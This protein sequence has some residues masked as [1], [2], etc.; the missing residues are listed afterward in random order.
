VHSKALLLAALAAVLTAAAPTVSQSRPVGSPGDRNANKI[1]DSLD[2]RL[3]RMRSDQ[4]LRV[5]VS[6]RH[7]ATPAAVG[8]LQQAVGRLKVRARFSII[9]A[10]AATL[11]KRQV[12]QVAARPGVAR[13]GLDRVVH[14]LNDTSEESFGVTKARL[15]AP[16]LDG[17]C[18]VASD[19]QCAPGV[20]GPDDLVA[21][22]LDTGIN[23][24][25][26]DLDGGKVTKFVD[27]TSGV[28]AET[29]PFDDFGHGTHVAATIAGDGDGTSDHRYQGVAPRAALVGVKVLDGSG[30]GLESWILAGIDWVIANRV[31]EGIEAMSLSLGGG[32]ACSDGLDDSDSLAQAVNHAVDQGLVV[33]VAAGNDG[34]RSCT[35]ATP[36]VASKV[37]TVGA[38][39]DMGSSS[40]GCTR[41]HCRDGFK[42]APF[43]SRG[44]TADQRVKP[45]IS[46]PGVEVTSADA[47]TTNGYVA[48]SGTS[49]ATPFVA[50]VALLMLDQ[51]PALSP[52]QVKQ[53]LMGSAVDWGSAGSDNTYGAGRL[54]AYAALRATGAAISA[55]PATPAH[56]ALEGAVPAV[57]S[58]T[59]LALTVT[60]TQ[61]PLAATLLAPAGEATL[62]LLDPSGTVVASSA[63]PSTDGFQQELG[64]R[65]AAPGRYV[66]RITSSSGFGAYTLDLSG[67]FTVVP[68]NVTAPVISGIARHGYTLTALDGAWTSLL[69]L[70]PFGYSWLRCSRDGTACA[71]IPGAAAGQYTTTRADVA[72]SLRVVVTTSNSAGSASAQSN[73]LAIGAARPASRSAPTIS[74]AP[75]VGRTLRARPGRW[76]GTAPFTFRY[77]WLRCGALKCRA[78]SRA[79]RAR[80]KVRR[81]DVGRRL[82]V[83]VV[84]S[85]ARLPAGAQASRT[86]RPTR[87]VRR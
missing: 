2:L 26:V 9:P 53:D 5:I 24:G 45:D 8:A 55:P 15:D 87:P 49:M 54:D 22:V 14:T 82:R 10:F 73:A 40:P 16:G 25:H 21:A 39:A 56:L 32:A 74:G 43:S 30:S 80:Y 51:N 59:D 64:Y 50:G 4:R 6:L 62:S 1:V 57:G 17:N 37:I 85:N 83:R 20:Y 61:F 60:G 86:S 67:P 71:P 7:A 58:A 13:I 81:A 84:A 70:G 46:A 38:M 69:P 75:R 42:E 27:C 11:T 31:T 44:P 76:A 19:P 33:T 3:D 12:E 23:A 63:F 34:P 79:K 47:G 68:I 36:G 35:V 29:F 41:N 28:C 18:N 78:I 52:A 72:H 66:V 48:L 77:Q 65:S